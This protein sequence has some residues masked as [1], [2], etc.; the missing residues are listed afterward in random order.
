INE[1]DENSN[2]CPSNTICENT[3][4]SYR[5]NCPRGQNYIDQVCTDVLVFNLQFTIRNVSFTNNLNDP[6][7]EDYLKLK[8]QL[9]SSVDNVYNKSDERSFY[10]APA[11]LQ[12]FSQGPSNTVTANFSIF[13]NPLVRQ[14]SMG[15]V[16]TEFISNLATT[17]NGQ[18]VLEPRYELTSS[19]IAAGD[20]N[21]C[22]YSP[23]VCDS[24]EL[25]QNY[26]GTYRCYCSSPRAVNINNVCT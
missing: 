8:S 1:C 20:Y 5:C 21:E 13:F 18:S 7:D 9:E 3:Y 2:L 22:S 11:R 23:S 19:S 15:D 10:I 16:R 12:W 25:C 17:A 24:D 14:M 26:P 4:A 6:R